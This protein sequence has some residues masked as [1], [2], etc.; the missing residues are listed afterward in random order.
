MTRTEPFPSS[1]RTRSVQMH[2]HSLQTQTPSSLGFLSCPVCTGHGTL[3]APCC[4]SWAGH[5]VL[6]TANC[7]LCT[8]YYECTPYQASY[9]LQPTPYTRTLSAHSVPCTHLLFSLL[10]PGSRPLCTHIVA[11]PPLLSESCAD[12][13]SLPQSGEMFRDVRVLREDS[14]AR[15]IFIES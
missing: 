10:K 13:D 4:M 8:V 14:T 3:Y 5:R 1:K 2:S 7:L 15:T 12:V 6:H 11:Q 9:T